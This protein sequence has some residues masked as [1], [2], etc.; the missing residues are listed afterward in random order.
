MIHIATKT[1]APTVSLTVDKLSSL[2]S[3]IKYLAEKLFPWGM[4]SDKQMEELWDAQKIYGEEAQK[5]AESLQCYMV[6]D[7][8]L[9]YVGT[10]KEIEVEV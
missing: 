8:L 3:N 1:V 7:N 6:P 2:L 4:I 5:E 9:D 10:W